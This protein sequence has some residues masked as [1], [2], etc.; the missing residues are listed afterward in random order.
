MHAFSNLVDFLLVCYCV[1]IQ[2]VQTHTHTHTHKEIFFQLIIKFQ[3][4]F[5]YILPFCSIV[6]CFSV[7]NVPLI[8]LSI[9]LSLSIVAINYNCL[10]FINNII[11]NNISQYLLCI[12]N[13]A[14]CILNF[15]HFF[16]NSFIY[17]QIYNKVSMYIQSLLHTHFKDSLYIN[18]VIT[19]NV[20]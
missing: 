18:I 7:Q 11:L 19:Y 16:Y 5:E 13:I 4:F 12:F 10:F 20:I 3:S 6:I 1:C 14:Y 9:S 17:L 15:Q 2:C 8:T